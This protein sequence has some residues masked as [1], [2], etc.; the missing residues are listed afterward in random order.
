MK[1]SVV[2]IKAPMCAQVTEEKVCLKDVVEISGTVDELVQKI[3]NRL[4]I[5]FHGEKTKKKVFSVMKVIREIHE[6]YPD[7]QV[8]S[9]G[10]PDFIVEFVKEKKPVIWQEILKLS[11]LCIIVFI[12]SAFTIM[13]FNTDVSVSDVFDE[14][15]RLVT[16]VKKT[17]GSIVEISY[18][19]GIFIGIMGFYN[20]FKKTGLK[21]DPTPIHVEMRNYEDEVNKAIMG[22]AAKDGEAIK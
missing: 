7:V 4:L 15:Y 17:R 11:L 2:Y 20:H 14:F 12:G 13:T 21:E 22:D 9:V 6:L 19:V 3:E 16:G 8:V 10:E 1:E 18:C 5:S